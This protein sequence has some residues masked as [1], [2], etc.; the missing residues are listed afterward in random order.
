[1]TIKNDIVPE[2][3]EW[4]MNWSNPLPDGTELF[5]DKPR[6]EQM[7]EPVFALAH[8]LINE[9]LILNTHWWEKDWPEAARK[10]TAMAVNC[11]DVFAWGCA[12]AET[13]YHDDIEPLYRLWQ[14]EPVW[15]PAVWCMIRRK[16]LPQPPVAEPMRAAGWDLAALAAEHGLEPNRYDTR[17]RVPAQ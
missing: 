14:K 2:D 5:P 7:F 9:V 1:V 6:T 15:G 4:T 12:D 11:S 16:E 13:L 17:P 10:V 3:V 8:L